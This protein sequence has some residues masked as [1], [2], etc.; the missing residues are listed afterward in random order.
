MSL[1]LSRHLTQPAERQTVHHHPVI[2]D[3]ALD[4]V[5]SSHSCS[6]REH[7]AGE[8]GQEAAFPIILCNSTG[9][10]T[11]N[12]RTT[13]TD[14]HVVTAVTH[15]AAPGSGIISHCVAGD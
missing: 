4:V 8:A 14:A 6:H 10:D 12:E 2:T 11:G 3:R 9:Q 1:L 7:G 15:I 5:F 13:Q